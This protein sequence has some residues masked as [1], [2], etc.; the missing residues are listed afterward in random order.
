MNEIK[1][2][3]DNFK[4]DVLENNKPVVLDFF[5]NWCGPCK[6]LAPELASLAEK[7]GDKLVVAKVNV[8]EE[9]ELAAAHGIESIPTIVLYENGRAVKAALG[10]KTLHDLEKWLEL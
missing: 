5:A 3:K 2:T 4:T 10:Y 6:M 7:Y 1:I 8:D 9:P